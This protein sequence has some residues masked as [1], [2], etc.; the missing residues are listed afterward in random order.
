MADS[1]RDLFRGETKLVPNDDATD[2]DTVPLIQGRPPQIPSVCVI[3]LPISI[4][5]AGIMTSV[6]KRSEVG[7]LS[8]GRR[9]EVGGVP[10][11]L[12]AAPSVG[13]RTG[14]ATDGQP[15]FSL[16]FIQNSGLRWPCAIASTQIELSQI[17]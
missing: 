17:K 10:H 5:L 12:P 8:S 14:L 13:G 15:I 1:I 4:A 3:K 11:P 16:R 9:S 7:G 6:P 2:R